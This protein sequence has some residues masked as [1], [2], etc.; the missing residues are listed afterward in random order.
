[1]TWTSFHRRGEILRAVIAAADPRRDG[2]LPM[3]VDGVAETF[4][5][6]L[7]CSAPCSCAGTPA[8]PAGSSAS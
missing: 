2:L 4:G 1:M 5:D 8:W 3:D 6:E 7:T